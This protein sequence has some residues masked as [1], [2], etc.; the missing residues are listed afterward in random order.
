M[1]YSISEENY[2]KAIFHLTENGK[3]AS[4]NQ[5][6][7]ALKAKPAS[8]TDM[9]KKLELKSLLHYEKYYG[10]TLTDN[11]KQLALSIIRKHRLWEYFLV[12]KLNI[13]W[14]EVHEIAEQLEH[15]KSNLLIEQLDKYLGYPDFDPH[16]D[17]I[18]DSKGNIKEQEKTKLTLAAKNTELEICSVNSRNADF[19]EMLEM[20]K[21]QIGTCISI[22]KQYGFDKSLDVKLNKKTVNISEQLAKNIYV[23]IKG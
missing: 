3:S 5:L 12:N 13:N 17:P 18:P 23:K 9:L 1:I 22:I 11:G 8:I 2:V 10:V 20:K 21:L 15:V 16:G 7:E 4:T 14:T 6:A 19:L